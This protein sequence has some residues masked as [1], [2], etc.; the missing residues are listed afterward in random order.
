MYRSGVF[1]TISFWI[2]AVLVAFLPVF[3][4]PGSWGGISAAK[5]LLLY[6]GVI[7]A[8]MFWLL[9]QFSE[10]SI[11]F[12][13]HRIVAV[14]GGWVLAVLA[15][16][17]A[18]ANTQVSLWGRGFALDSFMTVLM[19]GLLAFLVGSYARAQKRLAIYF[20]ASF[21]GLTATVVLQVVFFL[22]RSP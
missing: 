9:A 19:L 1:T 10:G 4:L 15:S 16:T 3:F 7:T 6:G 22:V 14:L 17:L 18:S 8:T 20:L 2:V 11:V 12:P 21:I 5:S 13:K